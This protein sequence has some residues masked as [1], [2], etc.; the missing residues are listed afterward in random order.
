MESTNEPKVARTSRPSIGSLENSKKEFAAMIEKLDSE[1]RDLSQAV[2]MDGN[3]GHN[4][5]IDRVNRLKLHRL[6]LNE[7][8]TAM[9]AADEEAWERM[10]PSAQS[11]YE[12]AE[13]ARQ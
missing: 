8:L 10:R 1:V 13:A 5:T 7:M 11:A 4:S 12:E 9:Q 6:R 2:R 3:A